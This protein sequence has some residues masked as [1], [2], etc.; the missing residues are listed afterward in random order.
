MSPALEV[1]RVCVKTR[2]REA[3]RKCVIVDVIDDNFVLVTGPKQVT[4]VKRRRC[5]IKHLEPTTHKLDIKPGAS[6][7]DVV[8]AIEEAQLMDFFKQPIKVAPKPV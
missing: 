6:D 7:E 8:K 1:G 4:G 3:G 2:G 5:N